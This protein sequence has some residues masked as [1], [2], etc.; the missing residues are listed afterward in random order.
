MVGPQNTDQLN[1]Y[2]VVGQR[3]VNLYWLC[4]HGVTSKLLI[5][6]IVNGEKVPP[7][8]NPN[9]PPTLFRS[10]QL[11]IALNCQWKIISSNVD[12]I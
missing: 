3:V 1:L 6:S 10:G 8:S 5:I 7:S 4:P 2:S 9:Q 12:E 11:G